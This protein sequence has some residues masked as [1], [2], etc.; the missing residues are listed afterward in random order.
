M[1]Y[2]GQYVQSVGFVQKKNGGICSAGWQFFVGTLM[3]RHGL[4][5][6]LC[7]QTNPFLKPPTKVGSAEVQRA[8]SSQPS[9]C[10]SFGIS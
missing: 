2:T 9:M 6:V 7:F 1:G 10:T 4:N 3:F 5:G 8:L